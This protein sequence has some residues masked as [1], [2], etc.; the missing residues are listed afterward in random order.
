RTATLLRQDAEALEAL[1]GELLEA[2]RTPAGP[3]AGP[4]RGLTLDVAVL[5]AALPA[6]RHRALRLA[7]LEAGAP[8]GDLGL[9]HVHALDAL[10]VDWSGQGPAHLPGGVEA[11]RRCGRLSLAGHAP[12]DPKEHDR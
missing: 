6:L 10:V 8:A 12:G 4:P 3:G 2:A 9:V 5:A 7:A 1:A 11:A